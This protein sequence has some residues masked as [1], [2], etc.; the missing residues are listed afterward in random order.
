M[1]VNHLLSCTSESGSYPSSHQDS[2]GFSQTEDDQEGPDQNMAVLDSDLPDNMPPAILP[3]THVLHPVPICQSSSSTT[4]NLS[5]SVLDEE[6]LTHRPDE[7]AHGSCS[8]AVSAVKSMPACEDSSNT[9][10]LKEGSQEKKIVIG[11][12]I[13]TST[14]LKS[15]NY[16]LVSEIVYN[17]NSVAISLQCI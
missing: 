4:H 1:D 17:P 2:S 13:P 5:S 11:D 15:R 10:K 16:I 14:I 12:T 9:I 3:D 7:N 6:E 8:G